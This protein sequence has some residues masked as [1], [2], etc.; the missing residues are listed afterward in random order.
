MGKDG[1]H[2]PRPEARPG[3]VVVVAVGGDDAVEEFGCALGLRAGRQD[4][5]HLQFGVEGDAGDLFLDQGGVVDAFP[6]ALPALPE[7]GPRDGGGERARAQQ[8][9]LEGLAALHPVVAL[10]GDQ[11]DHA[12]D[13]EGEAV[14]SARRPLRGGCGRGRFGP[15]PGTL[16]GALLVGLRPVGAE[17]AQEQ[18]GDDAFSWPQGG[19]R[20]E[21]GEEGVGAGVE[22]VVVEEGAQ[23]RVLGSARR[24]RHAPGLLT[25]I[26]A[27]G[28]LRLGHRLD[29]GLG[30]M[31]ADLAAHDLLV[32]AAG[33]E[34]D[35]IHVAREFEGEGFGD[36]DRLEQ[37]LDAE[38]GA[39]PG[40]RRRYGEED[41]RLGL[42]ITKGVES[43]GILLV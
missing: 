21:E 28:V 33:H 34:G 31:G 8:R 4:G 5:G 17:G 16:V 43:H 29:A 27:Q 18:T 3:G 14:R 30:V 6:P 23:G 13:G 24:E 10:E 19:Q 7:P 38:Q 22:Q 42:G 25:R 12:E 26:E 39:F 9:G 11:A 36:G 1:A 32:V 37:V 2:L 15:F 40:S 35:A 20:S 41:G